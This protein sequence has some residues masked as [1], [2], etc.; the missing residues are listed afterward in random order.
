VLVAG[1]VLASPH[2]LP[3][4]MVMVAVALMVYSHPRWY[5]WLVLSIGTAVAAVTPAPVPA[6]AGL[7]VVGWVCLRAAGLLTWRQSAPEVSTA[8]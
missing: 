2:S 8:R 1:G 4:D 5:D 6:L 7:L 3:T